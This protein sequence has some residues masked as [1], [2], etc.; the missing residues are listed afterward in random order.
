MSDEDEAI[1]D[2]IIEDEARKTP[3]TKTEFDKSVRNILSSEL[4][5]QKLIGIVSNLLQ[6][7]QINYF[8]L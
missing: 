2:Q 8:R 7:T 5:N 1:V 3:M 4:K 6:M